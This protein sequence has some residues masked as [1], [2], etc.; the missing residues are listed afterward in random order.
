MWKS[1]TEMLAYIEWSGRL[2][3]LDNQQSDA[4]NTTNPAG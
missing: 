3:F 1:V 4:Y 2:D